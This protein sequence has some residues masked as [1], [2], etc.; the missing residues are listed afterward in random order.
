MHDTLTNRSNI[1]YDPFSSTEK[2]ELKRQIMEYVNN[3]QEIEVIIQ[4][5]QDYKSP[6]NQRN[7][8]NI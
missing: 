6:S 3:D 8:R 2:E 5:K 4:F 1:S 7:T